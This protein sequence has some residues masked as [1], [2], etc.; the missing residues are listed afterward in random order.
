MTGKVT[1]YNPIRK[2]GYIYSLTNGFSYMF[3]ESDVEDGDIANGYIVNFYAS[4]DETIGKKCAKGINVI[5]SSI[6]I[7]SENPRPKKK[8]NHNQHKKSCNAN[9]VTKYDKNFTR[10]VKNFM[11]EQKERKKNICP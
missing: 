1:R 5:D 9:K 4:F 6:G 7:Y 2:T 8:P 11:R 3:S 10:F